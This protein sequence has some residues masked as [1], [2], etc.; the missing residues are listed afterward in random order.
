MPGFISFHT[1]LHIECSQLAT[2][3]PRPTPAVLQVTQQHLCSYATLYICLQARYRQS[4]AGNSRRMAG[5]WNLTHPGQAQQVHPLPARLASRLSPG[6]DFCTRASLA[7]C[8]FSSRGIVHRAGM[9]ALCLSSP[10][11]VAI[12]PGW[13][14]AVSHKFYAATKNAAA[15]LCEQLNVRHTPKLVCCC[16]YGP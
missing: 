2:Y 7:A 6:S 11:I 1:L 12:W 14:L 16:W 9:Y 5:G 8:R 15:A 10:S 13:M 4:S 3:S